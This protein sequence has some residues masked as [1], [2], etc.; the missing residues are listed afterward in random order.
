M[1]DRHETLFAFVKAIVDQQSEIDPASTMIS[2]RAF[3]GGIET[4]A[5]EIAAETVPENVLRDLKRMERAD[6]TVT[7][8]YADVFRISQGSGT[9]KVQSWQDSGAIVAGQWCSREDR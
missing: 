5:S 8:V 7:N 4:I 2:E 6:F 3:L 9:Q 1:A